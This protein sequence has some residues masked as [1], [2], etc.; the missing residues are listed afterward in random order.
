MKYLDSYLEN[1]RNFG[2]ENLAEAVLNT[3]NGIV[4]KY[5]H[6]FSYN[7]HELGLLLGNIQSGKTSHMFGIINAVADEGFGTFIL[8]TTDNILLQQQ[9]LERAL[10]DFTDF[11]ICGEN[12]YIKFVSN[13]MKKP[14]LIVLKKN[15]SVLK[16]WKNYLSS[17]N[18]C[19]GNPLFIVD[20]EADAASLNTKV[21]SNQKSTINKQLEEI[22]NISS[23]SIYLQV[24]GTP[25]SIFLQTSHSGWHPKF[26]YYFT[27]GE[28]Y[29]G[30]NNLFL[31]INE[32]IIFTDNEEATDILSD[33]EFPENGL[34]TAL[35][36]H[37]I[38]SADIF[39]KGGKV[40]NFVIHPSVK[41]Q[42]H[43]IFAEKIGEYLNE[44]NSNIDSDTTR[45]VLLSC[46]KNLK[47][48]E[49]TLS[50]FVSIE[51]FIK[52]ILE[53]DQIKV[54]VLNS[55]SSFEDS[56]QYETGIN[57]IVGGNSL[58]RGVTFPKLQTIYYC[59]VSK[60]PQADTM[61][62]HS[63]MF[64]YDRDKSLMRIFIPPKLYKI[65][66][67]I[68]AVNNSIIS[69][70]NSNEDVFNIKMYYPK[71]INPTRKNVIDK[72]AI[73]LLSGGVNYFPF[74][75]D[76]KSL[77]QL[78]ELMKPFGDECYS[79]SLRLIISIL[80][81]ITS[82]ADDFN[83]GGFISFIESFLA[84]DPRKQ[85]MLIVRR[86]RDITKGTGTLLSQNDRE[87]GDKYSS[88]VV[89]TMYK[90][91]GTKGWGGKELWVPNI[92]LPSGVV[93]YNIDS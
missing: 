51:A 54:L 93:Y 69:Q 5:I 67:E 71:G 28:K 46:Y 33:D 15:G 26:V 24:T 52:D 43:S 58:G 30:G 75:P 92:K 84:E 4:P 9:T 16:Q 23:S 90:V 8:L 37:L 6:N 10:K 32:N 29:I 27:P 36:T 22:R 91:T 57:I 38:S 56:S 17:T 64:G 35:I 20:D 55:V 45:E 18:F 68:N 60:N 77:D 53:Q 50:S 62:Q 65:F 72:K 25:Q 81:M 14:A 19:L 44:L 63:R 73:N 21:N 13:N 11:C 70:L 88:C 1:L 47:I 76:N 66:S 41:T 12:D 42:Q 49:Q 34:K 89:L 40:C 74:S 78:D 79:V 39:L 82:K 59:R 2:K 85:G 31:D 83:V 3:V 86:N 80:N 61:W 7:S 48:T 87:L